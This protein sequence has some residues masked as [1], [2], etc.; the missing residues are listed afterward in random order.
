[1][2][3]YKE[4][5]IGTAKPTTEEMQGVPHYLIDFVNPE[6]EYNVSKYALEANQKIKEII[7]KEK[8]PIIVGGTGLYI[9]TLINGIEFKEIENDFEYRKELEKELEKE[10]GV[11]ILFEKLKEIDPT[12]ANKID[13]NNVRR[14]IRALEIFKVTGKTKSQLDLESQKG[15]PYNFKI[16][17]INWDRQKLYDRI[18]LR[19]DIMIKQGLIEEV[20]SLVDKYNLSKTAKQA[21]GYKEVIEYFDGLI[22]YEDMIEKIKRESRRYAKRQLTWFR[23]IQS[24]TWLDGEKPEE[25]VK[26][27]C[28]DND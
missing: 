25:M 6:E 14:V 4:M 15:S 24:I 11:D 9:D 12:S 28:R 27:I 10:N 3:I 13:K 21:L 22:S 8:T 23:H 1:M 19:V 17:G 18:D 16:Y 26:I 20:R 2:Q 7:E 5:S